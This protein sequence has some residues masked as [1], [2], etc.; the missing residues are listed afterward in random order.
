[1][2]AAERS[3]SSI[4]SRHYVVSMDVVYRAEGTLNSSV[5]SFTLFASTSTDGTRCDAKE[6]DTNKH[7]IFQKADY[8]CRH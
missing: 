8:Y 7:I 4:G 3:I 5:Y 2:Q 6:G 1:M